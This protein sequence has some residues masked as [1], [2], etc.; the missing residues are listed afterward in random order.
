MDV[1][2]KDV[3]FTIAMTLDLPSLLR[4]CQ[5]NS[6]IHKDV[7]NNEHL[8]RNKLLQDYPDYEKFNLKLSL[9]E[10][11]VLMFQLSY[12]KK[13]LNTEETLYEIFMK[14]QINLSGKE[15]KRIPSFNLPNLQSLYLSSNELKEIGLSDLPNLEHI[16][17][18]DNKLEHILLTNLPKLKYLNLSDNKLKEVN[19]SFPNLAALYLSNNP[20]IKV[21]LDLPKL[22]ELDLFKNNLSQEEKRKIKE[23]YG[24]KIRFL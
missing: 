23:T 11:Y 17:L 14:K 19:L 10:T 13:I 18:H 16:Y 15:L 1:A 21:T 3:L 9:K 24:N 5:S 7:C 6:R 8:W 22:R 4:W 12:I 20:L 2:S